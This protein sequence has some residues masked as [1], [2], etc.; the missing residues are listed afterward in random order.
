MTRKLMLYGIKERLKI[1]AG[2][3][4]LYL[5]YLVV[6]SVD[7]T[8]LLIDILGMEKDVANILIDQLFNYHIFGVKIDVATFLFVGMVAA[9]LLVVEIIIFA[10]DFYDPQAYLLFSLPVNGKHVV[11][12]RFSLFILDFLLL[13][14]LDFPV[15]WPFYRTLFASATSGVIGSWTPWLTTSDRL[16]IGILTSV[17]WILVFTTVPLLTYL[18]IAMA[19]CLLDL[20]AGWLTAF[21]VL[22]AGAFYGLCSTLDSVMPPLV[23]M[24]S[25]MPPAQIP[26]GITT[27]NANLFIPVL[28]LIANVVI[29]WSG[30]KIIDR[31][32]NI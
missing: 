25:G 23:D 17:T 13:V 2:I 31:K 5:L 11:G 30:T 9:A 16:Y 20:S 32:L 8:T 27:W 6:N 15:R 29:F 10:R 14:V 28:L 7:K 26:T 22:G 3:V 21:I 12:S 18:L 19:K 24:P 1:Y 4:L